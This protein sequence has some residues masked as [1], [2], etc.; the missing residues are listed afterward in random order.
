MILALLTPAFAAAPQLHDIAK[1]SPVYLLQETT[2]GELPEDATPAGADDSAP[3][4]KRPFLMEVNF[5]GRYMSVPDSILDIW[6]F[7]ETDAGGSHLPRPSIRAYSAGLEWVIRNDAQMGAFYFDYF[8]NLIEGGYWDDVEDPP[9]YLDGDW[10]EPSSNFGIIAFGVNYY[11]DMRLAKW[12]SI[13]VGA[14]LGGAYITG[15]LQQWDSHTVDS[16][17]NVVDGDPDAT[18]TWVPAYTYREQC[19]DNAPD[20]VYRIP[21]VVPIL[22]VNAGVKFHINDRANIRIEGGLHDLLYVGGAAG[23]VF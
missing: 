13:V 4:R 5:R 15:D 2:E 7:N 20:D 19:P 12:F 22:D 21:S 6:Y 10:M 3:E 8:G 1:P 14:G 23:V 9:D 11:Y 18:G 16:Q 17:C